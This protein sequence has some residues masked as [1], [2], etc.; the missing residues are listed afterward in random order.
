MTMMLFLI[1]YIITNCRKL[2]FSYGDREIIILPFKTS[3]IL[4]IKPVR[5]LA[6]NKL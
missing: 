1:K 6:F 5:S 2:A 4:F 3:R